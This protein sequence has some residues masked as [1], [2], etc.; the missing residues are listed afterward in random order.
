MTEIVEQLKER[1]LSELNFN[2]KSFM[3]TIHQL[4]N[5]FSPDAV[6]FFNVGYMCYREAISL[7][8]APPLPPPVN[9][10]TQPQEAA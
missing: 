4:D 10:T 2:Y 6:R 3:G 7:I 5:Q 8:Q 9:D 1:L